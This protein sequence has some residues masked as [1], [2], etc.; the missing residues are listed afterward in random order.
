MSKAFTVS[1]S[2]GT[3]AENHSRRDYTPLSADRSL[4]NRNVTIYD[5]G[6]DRKHF[7]DFFLPAIKRYNEK[8]T[9]NDRKKSEDYLS[10][11]ENGSECYGRGKKQ[12]QPFYHDVIQ[13]GNRDTNG[14]T[15]D[16]FDV[17]HWRSLKKDGNLK[18]A[19]DYVQQHLRKPTKEDIAIREILIEIAEEI[20]DN[21][22]DEYANILVHGLQIHDDEPNGT[23]HLDFR[24]TV[25]TTNETRGLDTRVSLTRGLRAMG[26]ETTE[27]QTALS[28][29]REKIKDRIT[30]KMEQRGLQ[31]E[32]IGEHRPHLPTAVFEAEQRVK[33]AEKTLTDLNSDIQSKA[34]VRDNLADEIKSVEDGKA[35]VKLWNAQVK[36]KAE[37]V[38]KR[39]LDVSSR[40]SAVK[41]R[42]G[43]VSLSEADIKAREDS[44]S[45]REEA[46]QQ[47]EN[48]YK[49][50]LDKEY[51]DKYKELLED[52]KAEKLKMRMDFSEKLF[53]RRAEDYETLRK[54][55]RRHKLNVPD[56]Q[57]LY[58]ILAREDSQRGLV[59]LGG[60]APDNPFKKK[61][62][63]DG[64]DYP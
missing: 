8:Q 40:E 37:T 58:Q 27:S 11:V 14:V 32:V 25:F 50:V 15:D 1:A 52:F 22:D 17:D 59:K 45:K 62:D 46:L 18:D 35:T 31:R 41:A 42:E 39:E 38:K 30:E 13:I 19:S 44:I 9:R 56:R 7:N 53:E 55:G 34:V 12:E 63:E 43:A 6:D 49:A 23:I 28:K 16:G 36:G 5:C 47:R 2:S 4:K 57:E 64:Y 54:W 3:T 29:F 60:T 61:D 24:Y 20:R 48:G 51:S 26:Y 33:E 21:K 10:G